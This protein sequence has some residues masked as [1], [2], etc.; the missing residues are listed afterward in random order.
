MSETPEQY[1]EVKLD[2]LNRACAVF[3]ISDVR[4]LNFPEPFR[5]Q[6]VAGGDP[7]IAGHHPGSFALT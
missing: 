7:G 1:I 5:P 6:H 4:M 2:E 3:G